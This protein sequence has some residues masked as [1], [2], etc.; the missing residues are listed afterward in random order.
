MPTGKEPFALSL[1]LISVA[2]G[3]GVAVRQAVL[4][5]LDGP[6]GADRY[7]LDKGGTRESDT[8]F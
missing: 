5:G 4:S 7:N 3:R 8:N 6:V 2:T 1:L